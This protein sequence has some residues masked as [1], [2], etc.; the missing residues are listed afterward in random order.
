[1]A[2]GFEPNVFTII[3][4]V[5]VNDRMGAVSA[6]ECIIGWGNVSYVSVFHILLC[7]NIEFDT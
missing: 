1:M 4:I 2:E 7:Q 5:V 3:L 6:K